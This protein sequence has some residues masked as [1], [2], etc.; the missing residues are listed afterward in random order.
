MAVQVGARL[1]RENCG[2]YRVVCSP[3]VR[4]V[5]TAAEIVK[6][7][8]ASDGE[9]AHRTAAAAAKAGPTAG[10]PVGGGVRS[11]AVN[12]MMV[13]ILFEEP[14]CHLECGDGLV[15]PLHLPAHALAWLQRI[16][17]TDL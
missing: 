17:G 10:V 5:E 1:R 6:A 13:S 3:Y 8:M 7:L 11:Q 12:Q 4:C 15:C 16:T 14:G 9:V 2:P